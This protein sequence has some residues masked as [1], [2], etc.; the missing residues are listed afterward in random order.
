MAATREQKRVYVES[1]LTEVEDQNR[2]LEETVAPL[3]SILR[4]ALGRSSFLEVETL[5]EPLTDEPFEPGPL[6]IPLPRPVLA[7][8]LPPPLNWLVRLVPGAK[9]K[10]ERRSEEARQRFEADKAAHAEAE[11]QRQAKLTEAH[12]AHEAKVAENRRRVEGQHAEVEELKRGL[13]ARTADAVAAYFTLV[14]D[15]SD[16]PDGFSGSSELTY[17]PEAKKLVVEM[18]FPGFDVVPEVG[19]FKYVRN[20][21]EIVESPRTAKERRAVYASVIAQVALRGLHEIF[22]ADGALHTI[23]TVLFNGYVDGIDPGTGQRARPCIVSVQASPDVFA[24][25][26][27]RYVDPAACLRALHG[28]ISKSPEDLVPVEPVR[29]FNIIDPRFKKKVKT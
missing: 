27:L 1:R 11:G 13:Q 3:R 24:T 18:E 14:L 9:A 10:H 2:E 21:D 28:A 17:D 5:K 7:T 29:E 22:S 20:K 6:A 15:R 23:D 4:D 12:A 16:Y 26:D 25:F 8:Y 19:S